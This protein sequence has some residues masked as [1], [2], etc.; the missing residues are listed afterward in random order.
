MIFK[1]SFW[2]SSYA[3]LHLLHFF[4][5]VIKSLVPNLKIRE[6]ASLKLYMRS[7]SKNLELSALS[8]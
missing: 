7:F 2:F 6:Q 5:K 1:F 4:S 3:G 8:L